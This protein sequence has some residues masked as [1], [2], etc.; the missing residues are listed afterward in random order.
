VYN[1]FD[2]NKYFRFNCRLPY[3]MYF[4]LF[5]YHRENSKLVLMWSI[6]YSFSFVLIEGLSPIFFLSI[7]YTFSFCSH[8]GII[9]QCHVNT[10]KT[11]TRTPVLEFSTYII[12]SIAARPFGL[13][14]LCHT[15]DNVCLDNHYCRYSI[16]IKYSTKLFLNFSLI[17]NLFGR[18]ILVPRVF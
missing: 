14:S 17:V 5:R 9:D 13:A 6:I 2:I 15:N 1:I 3:T 11:I 8:R 18:G 7:I 10:L 16:F 4:I 12:T